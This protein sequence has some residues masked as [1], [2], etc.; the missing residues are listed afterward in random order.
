MLKFSFT[1]KYRVPLSIEITARLAGKN[2][3]KTMAC[4]E[5]KM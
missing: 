4:L 1:Q 5:R 3:K 2:S